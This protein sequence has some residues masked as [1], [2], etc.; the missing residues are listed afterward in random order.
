MATMFRIDD[1]FR[2]L[3]PPPR[4]EELAGLEASLQTEG[5]CDPLVVWGSEGILLDGHHRYDICT[6]LGIEFRTVEREFPDRDAALLWV[7]HTQIHRRNLDPINRIALAERA[8]KLIAAKAAEREKSGKKLDP[9]QISAEGETRQQ[10]ATLAGVSHDTYTKG[11]AILANGTPELVQA[12]RGKK[13]SISS[14]A[15]VATLP[16]AA[17]Q[18]VVAR[19]EAA[20]LAEAKRIKAAMVE[21][22]RQERVAKRKAEMKARAEAARQNG[23][24][25]SDCWEIRDGDC[26]ELLEAVQDESI[27]LCFADPPYNQGIDYGDHYDDALPDD[28]Y[29]AW[30]LDWIEQIART[31]TPD[32]SF[33]LLVR[34]E[35]AYRIAY[36]V[37]HGKRARDIGLHLRQWLTWYESFGVNQ[38]GKFNRC[39]R[40]LL[41]FT[42]SRDDFVFN[43]CDEIRRASDRQE[44]YN[45]SRADPDGKYWDDVWGIKPAIPRLT[46]TAKERMPG[47]PTQLPLSLLTPIVAS[48][49]EVDDLILD[50]FTGTGTTGEA[51]LRL[52]RKFLGFELSEANATWARQRLEAAAGEMHHD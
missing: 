41:W 9:P 49:S 18:E 22:Q 3:I 45:D 43:D 13:A 52:G 12:V 19:G 7:I 29:E 11:K 47:F 5:C 28:R 20:I 50:P 37:Q 24:P 44:I 4:P 26:L 34:H 42:K 36:Q 48:A 14:A 27:R 23:A 39:S 1:E 15:Q 6:R 40:P 30:C 16:A 8:E 33:W 17:Q 25:H 2:A 35:W 38:A 51:S 21:K 46:G 31:L 10:A 32:G